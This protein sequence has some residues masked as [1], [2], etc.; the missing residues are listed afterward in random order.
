M[1]LAHV[2]LVLRA[3]RPVLGVHLGVHL[4]QSLFTVESSGIAPSRY[5]TNVYW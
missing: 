3:P 1:D 4:S 2:D 5:F